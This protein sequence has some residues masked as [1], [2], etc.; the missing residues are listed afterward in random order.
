LKIFKK[1]GIQTE[2][3]NFLSYYLNLNFHFLNFT[4]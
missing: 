1:S 2:T 4:L 3:W